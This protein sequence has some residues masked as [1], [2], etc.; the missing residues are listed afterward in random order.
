MLIQ[1]MVNLWK[2]YKRQFSRS[3][4][5]ETQL[6]LLQ[7]YIFEVVDDAKK[8]IRPSQVGQLYALVWPP[9]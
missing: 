5:T 3:R 9:R 1:E 4:I 2:N 8:E 6:L 7:R